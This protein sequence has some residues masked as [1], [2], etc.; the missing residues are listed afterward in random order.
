MDNL[1][2][3]IYILFILIA[4]I[5]S[6]LKPKKRNQKVARPLTPA[7]APLESPSDSSGRAWQEALSKRKNATVAPPPFPSASIA[8]PYDHRIKSGTA[9]KKEIK[10]DACYQIDENAYS[11]TEGTEMF[12]D[13]SDLRK[14]VITAEILARKF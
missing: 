8:D 13:F 12:Q 9:Q 14:A 10:T 6:V 11:E 2:D 1:G 4:F 5:T 3:W 7:A